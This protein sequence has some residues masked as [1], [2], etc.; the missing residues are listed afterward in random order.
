M[1]RFFQLLALG[2]QIIQEASPTKIDKT[3]KDA[4][5]FYTKGIRGARAGLGTNKVHRAGLI[6]AGVTG[7]ILGTAG[8]LAATKGKGRGILKKYGSKMALGAAGAIGGGGL[9]YAS[10]RAVQGQGNRMTQDSFTRAG[11][12]PASK[13]KYKKSEVKNR[14]VFPKDVIKKNFAM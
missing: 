11:W 13:G 2:E 14:F 10:G 6:D 5:M 12:K 4:P 9:G 3:N 8:V 1:H 7:G